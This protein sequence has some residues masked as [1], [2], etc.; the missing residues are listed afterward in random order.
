MTNTHQLYARLVNEISKLVPRGTKLPQV[1]AIRDTLKVV[2]IDGLKQINQYIVKK[3]IKNKVFENGT[4]DG[5]T[6]ATID[7]TKFFGSNKNLLIVN[8]FD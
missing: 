8:M 3:T 6:V 1:D 5:Y 2:D 7:G 4:I